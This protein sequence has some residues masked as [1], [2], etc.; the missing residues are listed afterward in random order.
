MLLHV[1]SSKSRTNALF[2]GVTLHVGDA[3][4][5]HSVKMRGRIVTIGIAPWGV[6]NNKESLIGKDVSLLKVICI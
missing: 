5:N 4:N 6:L 1:I 2:I 3:L